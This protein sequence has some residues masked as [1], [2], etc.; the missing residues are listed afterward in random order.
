MAL[1]QRNTTRWTERI[2]TWIRTA[3]F[4]IAEVI[5]SFLNIKREDELRVKGTKTADFAVHRVL[6]LIADYWLWVLQAFIALA[7]KRLDY[8]LF[9]MCIVLWVYDFVAAG[10]FVVIYEVTGKDLSL[11]EDFRRA[12]DTING[13]SKTA[14]MFAAT[15]VVILAVAWTGPEKVITFFRKEIGSIPRL[16]MTLSGLTAIQAFMWAALYSFAYDFT[17]RMLS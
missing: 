11:G 7:M 10:L 8:S 6:Y 13:K 4:F 9:E 3:L 16:L 2:G 15:G 14:G 12:V 5:E 1:K 17:V